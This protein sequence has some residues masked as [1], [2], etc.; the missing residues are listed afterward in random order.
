METSKLLCHLR[1]R[2]NGII[3]RVL[4][5]NKEEVVILDEHAPEGRRTIARGDSVILS[6]KLGK[7]S[8]RPWIRRNAVAS[9]CPSFENGVAAAIREFKASRV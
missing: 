9:L 2:I 4:S 8:K 1:A 6:H 5:I 3:Y 7:K